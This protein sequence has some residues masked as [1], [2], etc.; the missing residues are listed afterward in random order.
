M[1]V[2][3]SL[4][5]AVASAATGVALG[6]RVGGTAKHRHR[7]LAPFSPT[8]HPNGPRETCPEHTLDLPGNAIA[9]AV[10]DALAEAPQLYPKIDLTGMRADSAVARR[11]GHARVECGS[12][13]ERHTVT[14]NLTFPAYAPSASLQ[15]HT[16]LV[17]RFAGGYRVWY[18]L[19]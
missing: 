1:L 12:T 2:A 8:L 11:S 14:V 5:A 9:D 10:D 17:A 16:V 6:A 15:Q 13:V 19:R 4:L 7:H 3:L 18:V